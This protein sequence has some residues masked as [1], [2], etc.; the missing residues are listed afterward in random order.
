LGNTHISL[1]ISGVFEVSLKSGHVKI[2]F[3]L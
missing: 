3:S 2:R 1:K